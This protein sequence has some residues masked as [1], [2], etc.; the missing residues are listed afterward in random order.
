MGGSSAPMPMAGK[1]MNEEFMAKFAETRQRKNLMREQ[2]NAEMFATMQKSGQ[3]PY[4]PYKSPY[5]VD[6]PSYRDFFW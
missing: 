4:D 1:A 6:M 2:Q 3:R 5:E